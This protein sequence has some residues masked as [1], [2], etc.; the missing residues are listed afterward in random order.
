MLSLSNPTTIYYDPIIHVK[1]SIII[2]M[3]L[4]TLCFH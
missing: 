1:P 2:Q 3:I 4:D